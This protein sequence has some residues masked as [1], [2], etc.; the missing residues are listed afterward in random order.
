[1]NTDLHNILESG[2]VFALEVEAFRKES[3]NTLHVSVEIPEKI[4]N[5]TT[6]SSTDTAIGAPCNTPLS[7]GVRRGDH[8]REVVHRH[9]VVAVEHEVELVEVAVNE[10]VVGQLHD[11][12]HAL[13]VQ[14]RSIAHLLHLS[15]GKP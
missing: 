11:Q 15:P 4:R 1:M 14:R 13:L 2:E 7:V 6:C 9:V 8:L 5:L 12:L 10:A 3:A